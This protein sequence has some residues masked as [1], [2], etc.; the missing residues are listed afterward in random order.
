[1]AQKQVDDFC[2]SELKSHIEGGDLYLHFD[3]KF[4]EF[5]VRYSDDGM[6]LQLIKYCPWCGSTLPS[7]LRIEW[8]DELDSLGLDP[9][10]DIPAIYR[11]DE[12]WTK[13]S[14]L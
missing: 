5:G 7:S 12:W 4:R 14:L 8:F 2:C 10:G 3:P 1:M 13:K 9:D 6:S 11:T